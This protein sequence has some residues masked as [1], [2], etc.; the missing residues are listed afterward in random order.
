M[1]HN[2]Q[3][4]DWERWNHFVRETLVNSQVNGLDCDRGSWDP[5]MPDVDA[6]GRSAGRLYQT[7]LS[8]LT[9]EVYYR[10]LPLYQPDR[11]IFAAEAKPNAAQA[12][13]ERAEPKAAK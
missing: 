4:K 7:S 9:L 10:Y 6:W 11:G 12:N 2:V 8:L 3:G 13:A 5:M 1:L